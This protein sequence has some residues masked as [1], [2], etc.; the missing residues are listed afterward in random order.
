MT[1][2]RVDVSLKIRILQFTFIKGRLSYH[3]QCQVSGLSDE[4]LSL[5]MQKYLPLF[6]MVANSIVENSQY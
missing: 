2:E 6:K 1:L 5:K 3:L 4:D